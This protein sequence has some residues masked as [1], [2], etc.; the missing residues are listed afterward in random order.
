MTSPTP[1]PSSPKATWAVRG[2][3]LVLVILMVY[4]GT[5]YLLVQPE[6]EA[7]MDDAPG[8][9]IYVDRP[10]PLVAAGAHD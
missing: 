3:L 7:E 1:P 10:E 2:M 6:Q 8:D 4:V 5:F 9:I